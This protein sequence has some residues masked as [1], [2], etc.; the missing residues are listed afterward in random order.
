MSQPTPTATHTPTLAP[1]NTPTPSP[2]P[3]QPVGDCAGPS[4]G[5]VSC[6]KGENNANDSVGTNNGT[7]Q[8]GATYK[9]FVQACNEI[10]CTK[11]A[12]R[13]FFIKP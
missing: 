10:G 9:W 6:W 4:D 2:T 1:T 8:G 13:K 5:R 7:V 3:T 12:T 11:S